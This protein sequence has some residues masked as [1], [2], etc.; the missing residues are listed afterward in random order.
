[1]RLLFERI[2]LGFHGFQSI[3]EFRGGI[4]R[5]RLGLVFVEDNEL[6]VLDYWFPVHEDGFYIVAVYRIDQVPDDAARV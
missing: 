1:M 6:L 3:P 2:H 5:Y 4:L